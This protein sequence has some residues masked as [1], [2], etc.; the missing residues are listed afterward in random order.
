MYFNNEQYYT[1]LIP[2]PPDRVKGL[3]LK[4][5]PLHPPVDTWQSNCSTLPV[6][7]A[8]SDILW[9]DPIKVIQDIIFN[10]LGFQ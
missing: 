9:L 5:I 10:L 6:F 7:G 1:C 2:L 8:G 4:L 3:G